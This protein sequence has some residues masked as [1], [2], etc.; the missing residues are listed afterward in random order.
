M[1]QAMVL[2]DSLSGTIV[3]LGDGEHFLKAR[4]KLGRW[5]DELYHLERLAIKSLLASS[6]AAKVLAE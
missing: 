1:R 5:H 4:L 2:C 6:L 3:V